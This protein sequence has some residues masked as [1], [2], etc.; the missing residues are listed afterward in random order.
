MDATTVARVKALLDI[1]G[2]SQDTVLGSMISA[3]SKRIEAYL[4]RP[5]ELTSRT[6][7]YSIK[8]RQNKLYLRAYPVTSISSVKI[9]LD[10]NFGAVTATSS[11]DYHVIADN[12]TL[13]FTF[14]PVRNWLDDN[15]ATAP[16]VIQV[17]YTAGFAADTATLISEYP[18]IAMA[19][20]LQT[21]AMWRRRDTPQGNSINVG[22]SSIQ[23]EKP[24]NLVPDVIEAL[25]PYR[26]LR[27][28]ANG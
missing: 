13:H 5:L 19:A 22:N 17:V 9:A 1:T 18:D 20:D 27:F 24:L 23:Y 16:D 26:R 25:S 6:E 15:Y 10:W 4:D 28:A 11:N 12:G 14:F 21:V 7:T 2:S 8:P 3:V